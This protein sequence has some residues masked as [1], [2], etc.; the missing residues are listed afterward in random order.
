MVGFFRLLPGIQEGGNLVQG[1]RHHFHN[2]VRGGVG[3]LRNGHNAHIAVLHHQEG[4]GGHLHTGAY[5]AAKGHLSGRGLAHGEVAS[6][7]AQAH[8]DFGHWQNGHAVRG[9][10]R[11]PHHRVGIHHFTNLLNGCFQHIGKFFTHCSAPLSDFS[12]SGVLSQHG[13]RI[14]PAGPGPCPG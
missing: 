3:R 10:N 11:L 12:F 8:A 14:S 2:P 6:A 4:H 5:A 1:I 13:C 9:G 7:A